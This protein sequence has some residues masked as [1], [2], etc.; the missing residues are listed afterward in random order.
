MS[1]GYD[2][3]CYELAK[4]FTSEIDDLPEEVERE[5]KEL[6]QAIQDAVENWFVGIA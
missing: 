1:H 2:P 6:A 4:H 5:T 3:K